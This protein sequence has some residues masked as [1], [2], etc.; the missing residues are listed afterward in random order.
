[1]LGRFSFFPCV[2]GFH[3]Y[4]KLKDFEMLVRLTISLQQ[5]NCPLPNCPLKI[6]HFKVF[7]IYR[8]NSELRR[9]CCNC[10]NM[11]FFNDYN[12]QDSYHRYPKQSYLLFLD[13]YTKKILIRC[14]PKK[15]NLIGQFSRM[16]ASEGYVL[17]A[18]A[19]PLFTR[20][21]NHI[22]NN[23]P[24]SNTIYNETTDNRA[25]THRKRAAQSVFHTARQPHRFPSATPAAME[26]LYQRGSKIFWINKK[27]SR[28]DYWNTHG[29]FF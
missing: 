24:A 22:A 17:E 26:F 27:S 18:Y 1:M 16:Q 19:K 13:E 4:R 20:F 12:P 6:L 28:L 7:S 25:P 11:A 23:Q 5:A 14:V 29:G 2:G 21:N 3:Y 8:P 9:A 15:V 10:F